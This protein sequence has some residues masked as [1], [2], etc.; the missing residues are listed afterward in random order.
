MSERKRKFEIISPDVTP[1]PR[2]AVDWE[3]CFICQSTYSSAVIV[4][5]FKSHCFLQSPEK[6]PYQKVSACLKQFQQICSASN[7]KKTIES[8][9]T[10]RDLALD[11]LEHKAIFHKNLHDK[12]M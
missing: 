5:P 4:S 1:T 10:E 3:K 7:I 6:L 8:Y 2:I 11:L 9:E 12:K